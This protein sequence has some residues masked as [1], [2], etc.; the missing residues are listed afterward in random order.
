MKKTIIVSLALLITAVFNYSSGM[1]NGVPPA[2]ELPYFTTLVINANVTVV[3]VDHNKAELEVDGTKTL[4]KLVTF[5]KKGDTLVINAPKYKNLI[6]DGIIY[7]PATHLR[8]IRI[9]SKAYIRS[10]TM[11]QIPVLDVIVNGVCEFAISNLG[12]VNLISTEDYIVEQS[13][14]VRRLPASIVRNKK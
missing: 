7:V 2:T 11:L 5:T 6:G 3:L 1:S 14:E 13:R 10:L 4:N 8:N 12:E 9:N